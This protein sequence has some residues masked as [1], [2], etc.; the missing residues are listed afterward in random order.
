MEDE[1]G[2]EDNKTLFEKPTGNNDKKNIPNANV[3]NDSKNKNIK[4]PFSGVAK[5]LIDK[6]LVLG[7]EQKTID[8]T[9]DFHQNHE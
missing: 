2:K 3:A 9:R 5:N 8:F 6:F 1:K 7:Y 4:Y